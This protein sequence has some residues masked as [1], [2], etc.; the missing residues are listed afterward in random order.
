MKVLSAVLAAAAVQ[1]TTAM[2]CTMPMDDY[3]YTTLEANGL[4]RPPKF[5]I[6]GV[7]P[8]LHGN[9]IQGYETPIAVYQTMII[10]QI[11]WECVAAY[12]TNAVSVLT[13]ERP[14]YI[15]HM[16]HHDSEARTI[17]MVHAINH[18]L[19]GGLVPDAAMDFSNYVD[20]L[21]LDSTIP[22]EDDL[23]A[24]VEAGENDPY[25]I[26]H[27][28]GTYFLDSMRESGWNFDGA[29]NKHGEEC[30]GD[31]MLWGDSGPDPYTPEH[32]PFDPPMHD[33][34]YQPLLE[35]NERGFEFAQSHVTPHI[36]HRVKP[37]I[38]R[39][40]IFSAEEIN[41]RASIPEPEYDLDEEADLAIEQVRQT[42]ESDFRKI[43][44][45]FMDNKINLAGGLIM[46]VRQ[47][48]SLSLEEQLMY[49]VGYTTAEHDSIVLAWREKVHR[50]RVRPTTSMQSPGN[51][52]LR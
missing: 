25:C 37:I 51:E 9:K 42:G 24:A 38:F 39:E 32:S 48:F 21:C 52:Y 6:E 15:G 13:F 40:P 8:F 22:N 46:R 26:G 20:S 5:W 10:D 47:E 4:V 12:D 33:K 27:A 2:S 18:V 1:G 36:G 31:C 45:E 29:L 30:S 19:Q 23:A 49:H 35:N 43:M 44:V 3:D 14:P 28:I 11:M 7:V 17:C 34:Y 50:E 41:M 16:D